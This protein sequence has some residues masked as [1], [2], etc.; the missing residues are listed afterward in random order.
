VG[1]KGPRLEPAG[2]AENRAPLSPALSQR[3]V[4]TPTNDRHQLVTVQQI[5]DARERLPSAVIHTPMLLNEE[6]SQRS[7]KRVL[8]KC[9]NL[10]VFAQ[11]LHIRKPLVLR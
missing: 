6:L 9:D 1:T 5:A 8:F 7:H 10:Q 2:R 11:Q 3:C 4:I